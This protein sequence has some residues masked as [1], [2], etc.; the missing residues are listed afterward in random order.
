MRTTALVVLGIL[1]YVFSLI[2][3]SCLMMAVIHWVLNPDRDTKM[4]LPVFCGG[5]A[6]TVLFLSDYYFFRL[7]RCKSMPLRIVASIV[8]AVVTTTLT[9]PG[10]VLLGELLE[11]P[12]RNYW[13]M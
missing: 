11:L 13:L 12:S 3:T 2:I 9:I 8:L 5:L 7:I 4:M 10:G 1:E 6:L